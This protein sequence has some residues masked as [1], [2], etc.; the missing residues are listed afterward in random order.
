[1]STSQKQEDSPVFQFVLTGL[2]Q[3]M[4]RCQEAAVYS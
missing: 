1:M 3:A 2:L 4:A